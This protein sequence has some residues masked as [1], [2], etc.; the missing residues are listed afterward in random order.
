VPKDEGRAFDC[1]IQ[2]AQQGLPAAY[3]ILAVSYDT[4]IGSFVPK[5][6]KLAN[7]LCVR[8]AQLGSMDAKNALERHSK[9][10]RQSAVVNGMENIRQAQDDAAYRA[11]RK[12]RDFEEQQAGRYPR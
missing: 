7:A 1:Y 4:G 11:R 2:A 9:Q 12:M 3:F 5:D 8:A 6:A 10:W